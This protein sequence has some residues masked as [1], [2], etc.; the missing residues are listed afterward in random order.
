M[1]HQLVV[2]G[3]APVSGQPVGLPNRTPLDPGKHYLLLV[4]EVY[5]CIHVYYDLCFYF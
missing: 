3:G 5:S 1:G 4:T 2:G